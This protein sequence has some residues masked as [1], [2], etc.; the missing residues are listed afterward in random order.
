MTTSEV[1]SLHPPMYMSTSWWRLASAAWLCP[2]PGWRPLLGCVQ[3]QEGQHLAPWLQLRSTVSTPITSFPS[4]SHAPGG[5]WGGRPSSGTR[6]GQGRVIGTESPPP[7]KEMGLRKRGPPNPSE[8]SR[9]PTPTTD[10]CSGSGGTL[11]G[12]ERP[13][14]VE[15]ME[16]DCH[17]AASCDSG[18]LSPG[19]YTGSSPQGSQGS[20]AESSCSSER[21]GGGRPQVEKA[22]EKKGVRASQRTGGRAC[23][24][25]THPTNRQFT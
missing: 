24:G 11:P 23:L 6:R 1:N 13:H 5:H 21:T 25:H 18:A 9:Q 2:G 12:W 19:C 14:A 10:A 17:S 22:G 7:L 15:G 16:W 20:G 8:R 4:Q 3:A